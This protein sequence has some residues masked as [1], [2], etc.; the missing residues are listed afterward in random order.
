MSSVFSPLFG[1][2]PKSTRDYRAKLTDEKAAQCRN[3]QSREK[4][5]AEVSEGLF[6][7]HTVWHPP[8]PAKESVSDSG[9]NTRTGFN[10][11][12]GTSRPLIC[13]DRL[14]TVVGR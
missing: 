8:E 11:A 9:P 10:K 2:A 3:C 4:C 14:E 13:Y 5:A 6:E 7:M 1:L 12:S